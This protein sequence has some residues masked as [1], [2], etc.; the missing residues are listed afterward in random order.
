MRMCPITHHFVFHFAA[1][2]RGSRRVDMMFD[3]LASFF[4]KYSHLYHNCS[5]MVELILTLISV[6]LFLQ[7]GGESN[8]L[9]FPDKLTRRPEPVPQAALVIHPCH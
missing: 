5:L 1:R 8:S 4:S 7:S 6:C 2:T 3:I 9:A